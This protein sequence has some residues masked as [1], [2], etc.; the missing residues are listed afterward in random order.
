MRKYV[1]FLIVYLVY[2][3]PI[4]INASNIK[5]SNVSLGNQDIS[6]G[7]NNQ[8]NF[9]F[10]TLDVSWEN[11]WRMPLAS[12]I[13][14]WDAAWV[15]IK[16]RKS[17][18]GVWGPWEHARLNQT[19]HT[20]G[21][22]TSA[23][24]ETGLVNPAASFNANSNPVVGVF[25][26]RQSTG[27]G[28]FLQSGLKLKWNYGRNNIKDNDIVEV[29]VFAVEM[30][31]IPQGSFDLGDGKRSGLAGNF[32]NTLNSKAFRLGSENAI[33]LGGS[34]VG[35][36]ANN[37]NVGMLTN[38]DFNNTTTQTLGASFPKG[39]A[40][41]Y[42]MK[43]EISQQQYVDFLNTLPRVYQ[44]VRTATDL[45]VNTTSVTNRFVMSATTTV[46]H[47]NGIRCDATVSA[48][49]PIEFYC[50]LNANGTGGEA[51]DGLWLACNYLSW[52]DVATY[53]DWAGLR[54]MTEMEFEKVSKGNIFID[55]GAYVWGAD[56]IIAA[57]AIA[58]VGGI[59]E[60][61]STN[62]ANANYNS[63]L[64][65]PVRVGAF[66]NTSSGRVTAGAAFFGV[67]EMSGNVSEVCV[68]VGNVTGRSYTGKHG[69]GVVSTFG[70]A[71]V[72]E[73]P[74]VDAVGIG[75]RGGAWNSQAALLRVADRSEMNENQDQRSAAFG[76]RGVRSIVC[77]APS[78][79]PNA[80]T[81][82]FFAGLNT[83]ISFETSGGSNYL[84][85]LPVEFTLLTGQGTKDISAISPGSF[86]IQPF[87][88]AKVSSINQ[89]GAGPEKEF[90][91]R[92]GHFSNFDSAFFYEDHVVYV[93]S[94]PSTIN[95]TCF[96]NIDSLKIVAVGGGGDGSTSIN[97]GGAASGHVRVLN[98]VSISNMQVLNMKVG[99]STESSEIEGI[100][101]AQEGESALSNRGGNGG[102]GGGGRG[103][104]A[105]NGGSGGSN[106][107]GGSN[108]GLGGN[109]D[110]INILGNLSNLFSNGTGGIGDIYGAG[111]GGGLIFAGFNERAAS[112]GRS[113]AG[114]GGQGYGAGAGTYT[115][116]S[117]NIKGN[118]GVIIIGVK[119]Q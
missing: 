119:L 115:S 23:T 36:I 72:S 111:G 76:G 85:T 44:N 105:G 10:I 100:I 78:S 28:N 98:A 43:Y 118:Q 29:K 92:L 13:N 46:Q 53:L 90:V 50:D 79:E 114:T 58:N 34:L 9:T 104:S 27:S 101:F 99:A 56:A 83:P 65:G 31:Y 89:C 21:S 18:N 73:W 88:P 3:I 15:F 59:N 41:F 69:D 91:F 94:N 103:T 62:L 8:S 74:G 11:S 63:E 1:I 47:R 95:V 116:P 66:S 14:N 39:F 19:G 24:I 67:M 20:L 61:I 42:T 5:V 26:Y 16:Y 77:N 71:N 82:D 70:T 25:V 54:P 17:D 33:T 86:A 102:S 22:G 6:A 96:E 108:P 87:W 113:L 48:T 109:F 38:D 64:N 81:G 57:K 49:D 30:V 107:T 112:G 12:G 35:N 110:D 106:G 51:T 7:A 2:N 55:S 117:T 68:S 4:S 40:A 52:A 80:V 32:S 97:W 93:F 75:R 84:W 37:N 45:A 60:I